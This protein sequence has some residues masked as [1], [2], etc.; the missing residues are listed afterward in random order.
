MICL[1]LVYREVTDVHML[2]LYLSTSVNVPISNAK[3]Y[4][5]SLGGQPIFYLILMG[6]FEV[7]NHFPL[8]GVELS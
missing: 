8:I 4:V 5:K 1:S 2:I 6:M 7:S 3:L